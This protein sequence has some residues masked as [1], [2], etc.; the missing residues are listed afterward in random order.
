MCRS[1]SSLRCRV[2]LSISS[3]SFRIESIASRSDLLAPA[4]PVT[5]PI[6]IFAISNDSDARPCRRK[7]V[8][9]AESSDFPGV[10]LSHSHSLIAS[11]CS[12]ICQRTCWR[13]RQSTRS[14]RSRPWDAALAR[15]SREAFTRRRSLTYA[16][17]SSRRKARRSRIRT[18]T[19]SPI[20]TPPSDVEI[21]VTTS[22]S[23]SEMFGSTSG[24]SPDENLLERISI[25]P[26]SDT[27][28]T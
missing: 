19:S 15:S 7:F 24:S 8:C 22:S 26:S 23:L 4:S 10:R 11:R 21:S 1:N 12:G 13:S 6:V 20:D 16:S 2:S 3:N 18:Q 5:S 17:S 14:T 25:R 9:S 27:D 28:V